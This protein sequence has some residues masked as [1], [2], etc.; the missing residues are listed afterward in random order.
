[1]PDGLARSAATSGSGGRLP[2]PG[3]GTATPS[4]GTWPQ[5]AL[6]PCLLTPDPGPHLQCGDLKLFAM[7]SEV[8]NA[9]PAPWAT[10]HGVT[11]PSPEAVLGQA[12]QGWGHR[13]AA[14][15]AQP[16]LQTL[17]L[18]LGCNHRALPRSR[19]GDPGVGRLLWA[20]P[21][22]WGLAGPGA[23]QAEGAHPGR[24][25]GSPRPPGPGAGSSQGRILEGPTQPCR[26]VCPECRPRP[27]RPGPPVSGP[28]LTCAPR[29]P[30]GPDTHGLC[31]SPATFHRNCSQSPGKTAGGVTSC[32]SASDTCEGKTGPT[33][34]EEGS[35]ARPMPPTGPEGG[36]RGFY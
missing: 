25:W 24:V 33:R 28:Q 20:G 10:G 5:R 21:G 16:E 2:R 15:L 1:M 11:C 3:H 9:T 22:S 8:W 30:R 14:S 36:R 12:P 26:E 29:H 32:C 4:V 27:T 18:T 13:A 23:R 19:A 31:G 7:G 6:C 34:W 17:T 35:I